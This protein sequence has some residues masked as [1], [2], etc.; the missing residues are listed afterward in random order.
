MVLCFLGLAQPADAATASPG[1]LGLAGVA[2]WL[3]GLFASHPAA[4][5][6][7]EKSGSAGRGGQVPASATRAGKGAG[8]AVKAGAG[9]LPAYQPYDRKF[10][11]GPA[12]AHGSKAVFDPATSKFVGAK[13]SATVSWYQNADGSI[14]RRVFRY[15]MNYQVSKGVWAPVDTSLVAGAGGRLREKAN[16]VQVSFAPASAA[17]GA[18][19]PAASPAAATTPATTPAA[20]PAAATTPAAS[21]AAATGTDLAQVQFATGES[22]GWS[23]AGEAQVTA[24]VSGSVASYPGILPGVTMMEASGPTGVKESIVLASAAAGNVFTFPLDARG[25]TPSLASGGQVVFTDAAGK[26]AGEIPL[27][28]AT[29]SRKS[30]GTEPGTTT[31][32]V[33]YGLT[34]QAAGGWLLT[35]TV[36]KSWLDDPSRVFPVTIDPT[37]YDEVAGQ[38]GTTYTSS[39]GS[40]DY[41]SDVVIRTGECSVAVCGEVAD[42]IGLISFAGGD[43]AIDGQGYD[44]TA[45]SL[46]LMDEYTANPGSTID[47]SQV[48]QGWAVQGAKAYPGPSFGPVIGSA[49]PETLDAYNNTSGYLDVGDWVSVP[50]APSAINA[51]TFGTQP[52]YGLAVYAPT[53]SLT[54]RQYDSDMESSYSPY[55]QITYDDQAPQVNSQWPPNGY[56][57][58]TL[59]PELLAGASTPAGSTATQ[60]LQYDF[61]VYDSGGNQVADSGL[62]PNGDWTVPAGDLTWSQTYYWTVEAYDGQVYSPSPAWSALSTAVPQPLITSTLS[63]NASGNGYDPASGN[64]TTESTDASVSTVGPSLD[65]TRDYNSRDW[66]PTGAFGSGWSSIFDAQAAEQDGASGA[67]ASVTVT[68]PDGSQVG[69]GKNASGTFSPPSGRFATLATVSGGGYTLTDKNDTVYSFTHLLGAISGASTYGITSVTDAVG[70]AVTFT[71]SGNEITTMTSAT[72][73][74]ALHLTWATPS[75]AAD[76]H[77]ATVATDPVTAGQSSTAL[78]W[79][80]NYSGDELAGVCPPTSSSTCTKYSYTTGSQFQTAALDAGPQS[81]WPLTE[82]SGTVAQSAVLA[83]E[84]TDN[85]TYANVT[86]GAAG[87]L[88]GSTATAASFNGSTS[89]VALPAGLV[90]GA[91]YESMSL[92]FKTTSTNEVLFGYSQDPLTA[93]STSGS[94]TPSIY[95]GSNGK[96]NAEYWYSAGVAPIV[97]SAAVNDGKWHEVVLAAAGNTQTLYLDGAKVGSVSG[98]VAV[99][100][101][102]SSG[103]QLNDYIGGGFL[104]GGWPDETKADGTTNNGYPAPFNGSIADVAFYVRPLVQSDVTGLYQAGTTAAD[105]VTSIVRPSGNTYATVGYDPVTARVTSVTDGDGGTWTV[106]TPALTGSSQ[107]YRAAVLGSNPS[108]YYRLA[109]PAGATNAYDEVKYGLATYNGGVTLGAAGSSPFGDET[110]A[111][112]DGSTGYLQLPGTDQISTGPNTVELWFKMPAGDINGGVLFDEEQC[113][114]TN[115]PLSCGGY[116]PA[117]YVGTDGRLHG[118]FWINDISAQITSTGLVNDGKWHYVVLSASTSSQSLYLDGTLVGT[119]AGTL[120]ATGLGYVYVGAG[121]AGGSWPFAPVNSLG[122]FQGSISDLAFYRSQL[123][124]GDVTAHYAAYMAGASGLAPTE[125]VQVG[126]PGGKTESY[127]YD[128]MQG[129][130]ELS[131]TDGLGNKTSYDYDSAGF[132]STIVDPDGDA[133]VTGYDARG[134]VVSQSTCQNQATGTC[135]TS[136]YTY[137][138]DDTSTALTPNPE[139]DVPLTARGDGSASPSDS[140]YLTSYAYDKW[141]DQTSQTSPP[142]PG[143]PSGRTTSTVYT[144]GTSAF[145][146]T[147]GGNAPAGLPAKVTDPAGAVTAYTY[148]SDGDQAT[149][150][151]PLGAIITYSYDNLGRVLSEK[152]VSNTFP[153]GQVT[154]YGYD[155]LGEV[156]SETSPSVTDR[157]TG[158]VHQAVTTTKYDADGDTLSQTVADATGGD[159]SR[160]MSYTYNAYDEVAT[161]TDGD[162]GVTKY[163]YDGYGNE[164]SETDPNGITTTYA[165]DPNGNQ[166]STTLNGYTGSPAGSQSAANLVTDARTYDPA[167]RL[168]SETDAMG[169]TTSFTYTDNGLPVTE[170]RT[171]SVTGNSGSYVL[172]S[173][174]YNAAG[175]L[176]QQITNNGG[177]TTNNT[178]DA[179][180]RVSA[181]TVDPA[182]V[183]RTTSYTY[184]P[185]DRVINQTVASAAGSQ[186][187]G[188]TYDAQGDV[189]SSTTYGAS[190]GRPVAAW[191]LSQ[192]SGTAVADSTGDGNT[193]TASNVTWSGG[194]ASFNGTSSQISTGGPV[195]NTAGSFTVSAWANPSVASGYETVAAQADPTGAGGVWFGY[196]PNQNAWA[197]ETTNT[198]VNPTS[199]YIASAP[200]GSTKTATWTFLTGSFNAATGELS[201]YVNGVLQSQA[202]WPS[203]F[204]AGGPLSMG[205]VAGRD[206]FNGQLGNVQAYSRALSASEITALYSAGRTSTTVAGSGQ[207]TTTTAYDQR[208]LPVSSTDPNGN[209][210][211]YAYDEAGQLTQTV[212]PTVSSTVYSTASGTPVMASAHPVT[213][214]GYNT[215]GDKT[216]DQDPNGNTTTY[217]YDADGQQTSETD[218]S[219]TPPGSSTAITPLTSYQYDADGQLVK[220]TDPLGHATGYAYDQLGDQTS[221]TTAD[222]NKTSYAYDTDGD[223][224]SQTDPTGAVTTATY[225]YM[226]RQLTATQV[227]RYPTTASLTT[228]NTYDSSGNLA[229]AKSPAGVVTSYGHDAA[230]EQTSVTDGAGNTISYAYDELGR[231]VKLT[232]PDGTYSTVSYDTAGN[233][234]GTADYNASGAQLRSTSA[235]YDGDGNMLSATDAM[236]VTST[237]AYDATGVLTGAVQPITSTSS[238]S[239][240]YGYD[241]NGNQTAYT[242]GNGNTTYA[243]YNSMGLPESAIEPAAGA[244]TSA[245]AST[246][247]GVYNA[248]GQLVTQ[249]LPGGVA[250]SDSYDVMGNLTGQS[251]SGAAAATASRTFGYDA[252]GRVTSAATAAAGTSGSAGYQPATSEAF[253]YND[254][255]EVLTAS[256]SAGSSS[257]GYNADGSMT[258]R[259]D[260]SGTSAYTYDSAGRLATDADAASG[261][262]ATYSYNSMDQVSSVSYGSGNDKQLFTYDS[263]HRLASDTVQTSAGAQVSSIG[264]AY[265]ANDNITSMTTSGLA[266]TGGG[267]GSVTNTYTYDEAGRLTGWNNGTAHA[268]GYDKDGNLTNNNGTTFTYDA[269]DELTSDG[270]N[271]YTYSADGDVASQTTS[272]GVTATATSDA[273]GQQ[274]TGGGSSYGYD[275]LGRL[276]SVSNAGLP[277]PVSLAYSGMTNE[278]A[279]DASATYSRDPAGAVTGVDTAGAGKTIALTDQHMDLTGL[280]APAGTTMAGSATWDP[281]GNLI[282]TTGPAVQVGF[283]GAWTDPVTRQPDMGSRFYDPAAGQFLNQDTVDTPAQGDPAAG[284]DLHAYVDDN[285]VTGTDPSGHC[286]VVCLSTITKAVKAVVKKVVSKAK[287]VVKKVVKTVK[288]VVAKAV[289]VAKKAVAVVKHAASVVAAKVSDAYHAAATY[290]TRVVKAVAK[291]AVRVAKKVVHVVKTAVH[292]TVAVVK[293]AVKAVAKAVVKTVKATVSFVKKHAATIASIAAGVVVFAGCMVVTGGVGSIGCGALAGVVSSLVTQGAKCYD[294]Q[295]GACSAGSFVKAGVVGGVTGAAG[296]GLGELAGGLAGA[297]SDA[298]GS[299]LSGAADTAGADTAAAAAA[300]GEDAAATAVSDT[301]D[302]AADQPEAAA[303]E[304]AGQPEDPAAA[305][306]TAGER[307]P[308]DAGVSVGGESFTAGTKVLT[309][310]GALVAISRLKAGEKVLATNTKTGKT[311]AET[312]AAVLVHHDT[313]RYDLTVQTAHGTTVIDTTSNH[314]FWD[315]YLN[316]WVPA[317]KL[318]KGEHLKTADGTI[319]TADGGSTPKVH[320]G[321]MWDLTVPGN[322]DH[323]FYVVAGGTGSTSTLGATGILVHNINETCSV[324]QLKELA[325]QIRENADHPAAANNRTIGVGQDSAGNLTA[326]SSNGFDSG[327]GEMADNLNIRRVP[328]I[329]GQHAEENLVSDNDGS[330]WP[331]ERVGTDVRDP[332]GPDENNCAAILDSRGIEHS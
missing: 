292:K 94:Y 157:I 200:A 182:G 260:A 217:T 216:E 175:Q 324:A 329:F 104:G 107:V 328:S 180:G 117:L 190:A 36:D 31:W 275:G 32:K 229:S 50:L 137:Y 138:P 321:W 17:V 113:A 27:A 203:P 209:T 121:A 126:D 81:L 312:V 184:D 56:S 218:P 47:V 294:G 63:Q 197:L 24:R 185:D 159:A 119:Q 316:Y 308:E 170:T 271:T 253:T 246:S 207:Q 125:T 13:S 21:P 307:C 44:V 201:L 22:V 248:D 167:G 236:G 220:Q 255:G 274:V 45:A 99:G 88:A 239:A 29:D 49:A 64:Y 85:A 296:G 234:T 20:S 176:T 298:L 136:Y 97:T 70:R 277:A 280:V 147:G 82:T 194:A 134:N 224:L 54:W 164:T 270:K 127:A 68:Y 205:A 287:A 87:P 318:K 204:N 331:L 93:S 247:T 18:V 59:T 73:G 168:A 261:T 243:T 86:L 171:S 289:A 242:N 273:Y 91:S 123:T 105:L 155:G 325:R 235:T 37:F 165:Y 219:Y 193:G 238:V 306:D 115:S 35:V 110:G 128:P 285:P 67:L 106:G 150:T 162:G 101:G 249:D 290:A 199:W 241:L 327:Q 213:T 233:Q 160:T 291:T 144:D 3:G 33:T 48:T 75:G 230:G 55:L 272:A 77:V 300:G 305:A 6:P 102:V 256:G 196:D 141:G 12:G 215:F 283:Q 96:L 39:A 40:G 186:S 15:P 61:L 263:L 122:Y 179:V 286:F 284:G 152:D 198:A 5:V 301:A 293:K 10:T 111:T 163:S 145:P 265:N 323:D 212:E 244:N 188:Y 143:Y 146:A 211:S 240:G 225:D 232:N 221:V 112:F 161:A 148:Y 140:T 195:L 314:L 135:S 317:S 43:V 172:Q 279:S 322:G 304:E 191:P 309:A 258:S 2:A 62:V 4:V 52:D 282:A 173:N 254:R 166:L 92:W 129:D 83:N 98:T 69:F 46:N 295:Q 1:H 227:E 116:D 310:S 231:Q 38:V 78:T 71:W 80:Y 79:T 311:T 268:Y 133:T 228:A 267:T 34:K 131:A 320:D 251:G 330:L 149:V 315:A 28:F 237:Y 9:Q 51:W 95:V 132:L 210:T 313:D 192:S 120:S 14:T 60:A 183:D 178:V 158:A 302:S 174:T 57:A 11:A 276:L 223:L 169:F 118:E 226:Q 187:T 269:R 297:A 7:T 181:Q 299:V 154:S 214:V 42:N 84:G 262:T 151:T 108:G 16:S 250:V 332:C 53:G 66:R 156:V 222:G 266:T 278:V 30:P 74:R 264:Y 23:V 19:T 109:D 26:Q 208:G 41:S 245:A 326:G 153:A 114:L 288:K 177:L 139:N 303:A 72:S 319:A 206:F 257:F 130:R 76:P 103:P 8:N 89:Y 142:V 58:P 124:A 281:W 65:V 202:A 189:T 259:T 252:D 90:S 100:G 25:L